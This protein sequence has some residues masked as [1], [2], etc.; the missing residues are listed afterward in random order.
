MS[1]DRRELAGGRVASL[2]ALAMVAFAANSLLCRAALADAAIDAATFTSIRL[3]TGAVVLVCLSGWPRAASGGG[4]WASAFWLFV[5]ALGFSLAYRW[6][7]A[8]VGALVLFGSVQLTMT[9]AALV[10]GE[11][12]GP[13]TWS[14]MTLAFAGLVVLV[15]PGL[16]RPDPLG[17]AVMAIAGVAWGMYSLRGRAVEA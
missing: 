10:R 12:P 13:A 15:G 9:A 1:D 6:V 2:V 11:R 16:H 7:G 5:Y 3:L 14:G 17:A 8:A 4:N